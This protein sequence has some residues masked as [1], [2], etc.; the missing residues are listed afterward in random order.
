MINYEISKLGLATG[1]TD[2]IYSTTT[3]VYPD[4]DKIDDEICI[5]AQVAAVCCG[6]DFLLKQN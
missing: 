2:C 3:E 4:S 6:L 5:Q 1:M